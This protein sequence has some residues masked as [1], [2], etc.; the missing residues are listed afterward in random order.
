V[1]RRLH[2][3]PKRIN[4]FCCMFLPAR[5]SMER[6]SADPISSELRG[7]AATDC[8]A[9]RATGVG[10]QRPKTAASSWLSTH[11]RARV[12]IAME[13]CQL[14]QITKP[15]LRQGVVDQ[16]AQ[17]AQAQLRP[18]SRPWIACLRVPRRTSPNVQVATPRAAL[19]SFE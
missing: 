1:Y 15:E 19:A 12:Q 13:R 7:T 10:A 11:L 16:S 8:M 4:M 3:V 17:Q 14:L 5:S 6:P 9:W 2:K 18:L